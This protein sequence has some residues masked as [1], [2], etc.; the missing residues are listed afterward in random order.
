MITYITSFQLIAGDEQV[1]GI[2]HIEFGRQIKDY[3]R[4]PESFFLPSLAIMF[5]RETGWSILEQA[6][7]F[8]NRLSAMA[9]FKMSQIKNYLLIELSGFKIS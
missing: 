8:Q 3:L 4:N 6:G 9:C 7:P 2:I 5:A 1:H